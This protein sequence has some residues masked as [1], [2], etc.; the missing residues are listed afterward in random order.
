[1]AEYRGAR[2]QDLKKLLP[3][4]E[5]YARERSALLNQKLRENFM[6]FAQGSMAQVLEHPAAFVCLAEQD[7]K[8]VGYAAGLIQ[9]PPPLFE[10]D[11]FV[12]LSDLYVEPAFRGRGIG[13]ALVERV[14]GWGLMRGVSR[15][16]MV[17]PLASAAAQKVADKSGARPVEGL[18]YWQS[19]V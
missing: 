18:Y 12:F 7:G 3:L 9:E 19:S 1:M 11:P 17:V 5:G 14:R 15:C 4:L 8:L 13:G 6:E 2:I 16:S 10:D